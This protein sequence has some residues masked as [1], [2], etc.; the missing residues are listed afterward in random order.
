MKKTTKQHVL[1]TGGAGYVGSVLV[2]Y[3]LQ[4]GYNITVFD[5]FY[6]GG[7]SLRGVLKQIRVVK[8]DVRN[9]PCGLF[10]D[11]HAVIHL[12]AL[13]ND[14]TAEFNP[15]A[16]MQIN[17]EGTIAVARMAQH[18]GVRRFI[19]ASSC[20]IYNREPQY[21]KTQSESAAVFPKNPYSLSKFLAEQELLKMCTNRFFVTILRKGTIYG[22]SPRMRYDLIINTMVSDALRKKQIVVYNG[23]LQWRPL[24]AVEDVAEAY[25]R[26][27]RSPPSSI[28]G[29]IF[30]IAENNYQV[31]EVAAGVVSFFR[32]KLS[33]SVKQQYMQCTTPDRSYKVSTKKAAKVLHFKP[34]ISF[35]QAISPLVA[36]IQGNARYRRYSSPIYYNIRWMKPILAA[37]E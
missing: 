25:Y 28:Q 19:F 20:S 34:R 23:G 9:P 12:A 18:A 3:L 2:P 10:D 22:F 21:N 16:N 5:S 26:V 32:K 24:V 1:V 37:M 31:K 13:S 33:F 36:S 7:A 4:R 11:V 14:P 15:T 17:K 27:L 29:E 6:F 8:G 35:L 30:N